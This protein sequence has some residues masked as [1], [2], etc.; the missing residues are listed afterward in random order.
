LSIILLEWNKSERQGEKKSMKKALMM[1]N[2]SILERD[3]N[4]MIKWQPISR[5][6]L[7]EK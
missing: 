6:N 2:D 7:E 4:S 3:K 1:I 5:E